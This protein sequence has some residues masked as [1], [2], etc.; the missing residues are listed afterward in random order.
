V[1]L[2]Q[3]L[4]TKIALD[5]ISAF[6]PKWDEMAFRRLYYQLAEAKVGSS[7]SAIRYAI[8]LFT[9]WYHHSQGPE[10]NDGRLRR[11]SRQDQRQSGRVR[12]GQRLRRL[13][14]DKDG[15]L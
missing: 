2:F 7:S 6:R 5:E 1:R 4:M 12:R 3:E 14:E 8:I 9:Q 13:E 15:A 11:S 10:G